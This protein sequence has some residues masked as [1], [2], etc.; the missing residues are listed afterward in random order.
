MLSSAS[1][2]KPVEPP[3]DEKS[4]FPLKYGDKEDNSQP[5][6]IK[7]TQLLLNK[8][9]YDQSIDLDVDSHYGKRTTALVKLFQSL[10]GYEVTGKVTEAMFNDLSK[11]KLQVSVPPQGKMYV[12]VED[13]TN[14]E[15]SYYKLVD[16]PKTES[17]FVYEGT[18]SISTYKFNLDETLLPEVV[19][20]KIKSDAVQYFIGISITD[21]AYRLG[22]L[23]VIDL[24]SGKIIYGPV[25]V[26]CKGKS[27]VNWDTTNGYTPTG[28]YF[29]M[30]NK[31][32]SKGY[33][34]GTYYLKYAL[35]GNAKK[36]M[37]YYIDSDGK[38]KVKSAPTRDEILIHGNS[39]GTIQ[40][41]KSYLVNN[42]LLN[43][44]GC[45]RMY[46]EHYD[47]VSLTADDK[48]LLKQLNEDNYDHMKELYGILNGK[49]AIVCVAE[50]YRDFKTKDYHTYR[51]K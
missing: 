11:G 2:V 34:S 12:F 41:I 8:Y 31:Y 4:K 19:R 15:K 25:T 39:A 30:D 20:N 42:I 48:K 51:K 18:G 1:G 27:G 14:P 23:E 33:D 22:R 13:T 40:P 50:D 3:K 7:E 49:S 32:G 38:E 47:K 46:D 26:R 29:A 16:K 21:E 44:Y 37:K 35:G 5:N 24:K 36:I 6:I 9:C 43:T 45:I 17:P 28:Y 10:N